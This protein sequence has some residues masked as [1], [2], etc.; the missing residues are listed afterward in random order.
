MHRGPVP[1]HVLMGI[2]AGAM[3]LTIVLRKLG[4]KTRYDDHPKQPLSAG[5]KWWAAGLI[6]LIFLIYVALNAY[7]NWQRGL[8][9]F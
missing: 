4:I 7:D 1:L 5:A 2:F 9:Q 6:L 3:V 8:P